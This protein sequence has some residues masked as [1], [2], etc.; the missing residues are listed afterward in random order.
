M[1]EQH[2]IL[3]DYDRKW[4]CK[5]GKRKCET[6]Y[7]WHQYDEMLIARRTFISI[8]NDKIA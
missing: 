1:E 7:N 3:Y 6:W 8:K 5:K 4:E 2:E